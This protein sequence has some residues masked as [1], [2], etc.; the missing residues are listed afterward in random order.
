[1]LEYL[2]NAA[3]KP[4]A[5]VLIGILA[6][7][8]VGWGVAEWIFGGAASDTTL[9]RVGNAEITIQQFS[10]EKS[11]LLA[12]MSRE[13]QR[14]T[15][16]D[17]ML[18]S[19]L[20]TRAMSNLTTQ[21]MADERAADLGFVVSDA[22]I[23][24]EI[25][26]FPEFQ[27][28]GQFS[29]YAF[30]TVLMNSGYTE[31]AF[32]DVLRK[33]VLRGYTLGAMSVPV[34]VPEF[35]VR[36]VFD[37]RYAEREIEYA[38]VDFDDFDVGTPTE[39]QLRAFYEQN[40]QVVPEQRT[41]SYVIVN[42]DMDAPDEYDAAYERAIA[43]EDAII[44][45]E[46]M[47]DAA[48]ANGAKY[49]SLGT[50]DADHRPVDEL[51]TDNMMA[52]IFDMDQGLE[53]ELIETKKGFVIVRVDNVTESHKAQFD[54]KSKDLVAD[55]RRAEQRK[56][57]YVRANELL[58]DLNKTNKLAGAKD[59]TVTRADGA[60]LEVLAATF[61]GEIGA[62]SIVNGTDAFYVLHIDAEVMPDADDKKM[63]D[64]RSELESIGNR[65]ITDDYNEFLSREYPVEI[66]EKVYNR[67]FAK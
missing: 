4:L 22:Q 67:F 30:D 47:A 43:V 63:A 14:E 13:E 51:L 23:A 34:A 49:V 25:R 65:N 64:I 16:A 8:F 60:P 38:T 61:A 46:T 31:A 18:I 19:A 55:W 12:E 15:Y 58:V 53:S 39:E 41:V 7:S 35:A 56:Q 54:A 1:M 10:M 29:T 32:A 6:F 50:F 21:A 62:N 36:A 28:D 59:V 33:Q 40:P 44:G 17:P 3:D 26:A 27:I 9:V 57:A 52:R 2:R 45:G 5:K 24:R 11:R 20:D 37:A 48:A 66:N 42:A